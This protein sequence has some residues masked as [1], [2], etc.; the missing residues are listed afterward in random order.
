MSEKFK[1]IIDGIDY[2]SN[3]YDDDIIPLLDEKLK[4][5]MYLNSYSNTDEYAAIYE[6]LSR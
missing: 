3:N 1:V 5:G 4:S 6:L 2:I